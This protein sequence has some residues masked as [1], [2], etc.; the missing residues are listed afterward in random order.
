[1]RITGAHQNPY[2]DAKLVY[3]YSA[4]ESIVDA[5]TTFD[6]ASER[7][8]F[9]WNALLR[10]Y[11]KNGFCETKAMEIYNQM[12][13]SSMELDNFTFSIML[14]ACRSLMDLQQGMEIH[15][16]VIKTG[17]ELDVFVGGVLMDMYCRCR[18]MEDETQVFEE[19]SH[20]DVVT[21]KNMIVGL[22]HNGF[23]GEALE[24]FP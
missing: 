14:K 11:V 20:R 9:M 2:L 12:K 13:L 23:H 24:C 16:Q 5:R 4:Y 22:V 8:M 1:M 18:S 19:M 10:A 15:G 21:W 7:T 6:E 3:L 17:Y